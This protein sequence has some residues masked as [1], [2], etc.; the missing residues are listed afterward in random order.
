MFFYQIYGN[1]GHPALKSTRIRKPPDALMFMDSDCF[2]VYYPWLRAFTSDSD[3]DGVGDSAQ[4]YEPYSHGRPTVHNGGAN[5]A[6]LDG[7]DERVAFSR[8]WAI[9]NSPA[10]G[11]PAHSFWN[12]ED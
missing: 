8:L 2:C 3:S 6:R 10:A 9:T 5:V 12:L 4:G 7:H 1:G 11:S